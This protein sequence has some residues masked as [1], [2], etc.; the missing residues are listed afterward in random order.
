MKAY[1]ITFLLAMTPISE[2]RGAIPYALANDIASPWD[3]LIPIFGNVL[4][5]PLL[6]Y[7]LEPI[8]RWLRRRPSLSRINHWVDGYQKRAVKKLTQHQRAL[9]L[10]LFLFVAIPFPTT[11]VYSG[12]VA[13]VVLRLPKAPA[14]VVMALG[15]L[16]AAIAVYLGSLGVIHLF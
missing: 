16:T 9:L 14:M 8:F 2:V 6:L 4:L 3:L 5:I 1:I 13:A 15:V 7:L 10:G 12:A 11:G